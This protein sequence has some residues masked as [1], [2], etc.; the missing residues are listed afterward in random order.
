MK[1][2]K[3]LSSVLLAGCLIAVPAQAQLIVQWTFETSQPLGGATGHWFT[4]ISAEVGT[5]TASLFHQTQGFGV[6]NVYG[7][8]SMH[9]LSSSNWNVGDFY[10]FALSTSGSS[11]IG[12]SFDITSGSTGPGKYLLEYST[13]GVNF[14]IFG[15]TNSIVGSTNPFPSWSPSTYNP[16]YTS[17][18]DLS[19]VT[20]L[21]NASLVVFRLV[22]PS[23]VSANG[24]IVNGGTPEVVDNFTVFVP[25]PG[26]LWVLLATG[27][28]TWVHGRRSRA[29]R[30]QR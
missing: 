18:F 2:S 17:T 24:G 20:A 4:N 6:I 25:E 13:D 9:C 26:T 5:G 19:A 3:Q 16:I 7:N 28:G 23:T 30:L 11:H 8:G 15:G 12:V 14:T 10:Q 1:T 21:N 22:D 29:G 27:L